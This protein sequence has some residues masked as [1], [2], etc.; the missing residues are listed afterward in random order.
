M[1]PEETLIFILK[2]N[3]GQ[4]LYAKRTRKIKKCNR[5]FDLHT[6]NSVIMQLWA[7]KS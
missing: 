2:K 3:G 5:T 4:M 7:E 6:A 1:N